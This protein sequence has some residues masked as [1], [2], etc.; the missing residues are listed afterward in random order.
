VVFFPLK[1]LFWGSSPSN[2]PISFLGRF[3]K[4]PKQ[5]SGEVS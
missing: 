4:L 5:F 2:C 3:L 1:L